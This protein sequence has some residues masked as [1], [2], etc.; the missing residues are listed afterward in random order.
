V[1][2]RM[3]VVRVK[4]ST[5]TPVLRQVEA[6]CFTGPR[7]VLE[8][9][10]SLR[11]LN[12]EAPGVEAEEDGKDQVIEVGSNS[13]G[14]GRHLAVHWKRLLV[15]RGPTGMMSVDKSHMVLCGI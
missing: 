11:Q 7:R 1:K 3:G 5:L 12:I 9:D 15:P 2:P 13:F 6:F 10:C 8:Y 14:V 4:E